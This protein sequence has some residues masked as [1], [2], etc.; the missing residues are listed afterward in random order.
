MCWIG[1]LCNTFHF[2]SHHLL[3]SFTENGWVSVNLQSQISSSGATLRNWCFRTLGQL[4]TFEITIRPKHELVTHGPY[5]WVRHPS[6]TG[7]YLTLGG[8]TLVLGSPQTWISGHF[9]RTPIGAFLAGFWLLK[10]A[11]AFHGMCVR[12]RAEDEVL[13][14]TFG[15]EW[16]DYANQVPYKF[17]PGVV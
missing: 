8:A 3:C 6:Y 9:I 13:K 12:L 1:V 11:F 5:A 7:V 14:K 17:I 16:E 15:P 2:V 10:C 4:F